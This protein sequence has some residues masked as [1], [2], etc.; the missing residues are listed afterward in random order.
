MTYTATPPRVERLK[1]NASTYP[2]DIITNYVTK[3]LISYQLFWRHCIRAGVCVQANRKGP[4]TP[5]VKGHITATPFRNRA[6]MF[7]YG[8][9]C[10]ISRSII[11]ENGTVEGVEFGISKWGWGK[12]ANLKPSHAFKIRVISRVSAVTTV[13]MINN[14]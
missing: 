2:L 8:W 12:G 9:L 3:Q 11:A 4:P 1:L 13:G 6:F 14:A 5:Y 10:R 7:I